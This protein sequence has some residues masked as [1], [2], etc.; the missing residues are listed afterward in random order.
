ME[1]LPPLLWKK[2]WIK[3]ENPAKN[4]RILLLPN[5]IPF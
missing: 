3:I 5:S 4:F 1:A 2:L